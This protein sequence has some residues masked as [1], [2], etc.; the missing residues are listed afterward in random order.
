MMYGRRP[1]TRLEAALYAAV[2]AVLIAV[3]LDRMLRLLAAAERDVVAFTVANTEAALGTRLAVAV[4]LDRP[5]PPDWRRRNPFD[6]AGIEVRNYAG[7]RPRPAPGDLERGAWAFDSEA[8]EL[9]YRPRYPIGLQIAD[10]GELLRF[11]LHTDPRQVQI[12]IVASIPY[13]W[14]P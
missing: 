14:N 2:V 8:R 1:V 6:V 3:F 5:L 4:L 13:T 12:R 9:V 10:G 7:E 11:K